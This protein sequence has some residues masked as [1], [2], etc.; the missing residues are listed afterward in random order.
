MPSTA[1]SFFTLHSSLFTLHSLPGLNAVLNSVSAV[2]L[3][4]G[5]LCIRNKKVTAHKT[6]MLSAFT[7]STLFLVSYLV[8][9]AQVGSV[10]F[11]GRGWV[12][13]VYFTIL[14]S[15]TALAVTIVPLALITL[16]RAVRGQFER[17]RSIARWTLPLWLYVN[18]TGVVIYWMLYRLFRAA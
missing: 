13:P 7:T 4:T 12:R 5:Y 14:V 1:F 15:H 8:Y 16:S 9:H 18:V 6:C 10:R 11:P 2:L 17:H 3:V